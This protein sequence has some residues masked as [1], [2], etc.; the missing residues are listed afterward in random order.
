VRCRRGEFAVITYDQ[1]AVETGVGNRITR[2]H[3]PAGVM[4]LHDL[5]SKRRPAD[6]GTDVDRR[7]ARLQVGPEPQD[8]LGL[9]TGSDQS[10]QGNFS[11]VSYG[12]IVDRRPERTVQ[13]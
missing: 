8:D 5:E 3:F 1:D 11:A 10:L 2:F 12:P 7:G 9:D 13:A 4:A 6:R